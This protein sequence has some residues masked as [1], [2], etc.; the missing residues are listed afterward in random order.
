MTILCRCEN[1]ETSEGVPLYVTGVAQVITHRLPHG[2]AN[3]SASG[4]SSSSSSSSRMTQNEWF[5]NGR[6]QISPPSSPSP[7][8]AL[9]PGRAPR[10]VGNADRCTRGRSQIQLLPMALQKFSPAV[11]LPSA[12][13]I[14]SCAWC[15]A[16]RHLLVHGRARLGSAQPLGKV[17]SQDLCCFKK[18]STHPW[19]NCSCSRLLRFGCGFPLSP[20]SPTWKQSPLWVLSR[21]TAQ[22]GDPGGVATQRASVCSALRAAANQRSADTKPP[23]DLHSI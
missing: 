19:G 13:L 5:S 12:A 16:E 23:W 18:K 2:A 7:S 21:L 14:A 8:L 10:S 15:R 9:A 20:S 1:I 11:T 22:H 17:G 6:G 4:S 3:P